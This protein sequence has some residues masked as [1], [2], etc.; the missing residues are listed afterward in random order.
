M[1]SLLS[2]LQTVKKMLFCTRMH[3]RV[4]SELHKYWIFGKSHTYRWNINQWQLTHEYFIHTASK[5]CCL[6]ATLDF[7]RNQKKNK[8]GCKLSIFFGYFFG[9]KPQ[10]RCIAFCKKPHIIITV[11]ITFTGN[12]SSFL[13]STLPL[14]F[15][16]FI[17][18]DN[19][20]RLR[21]KL[22]PFANKCYSGSSG[23]I[24]FD[25][26]SCQKIQNNFGRE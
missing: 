11:A 18:V 10:V 13:R 15:A 1:L 2:L 3:T 5:V 16:F 6:S 20:L 9:S 24:Y 17:Y 8:S 25:M 26:K 7:S 22:E 14:D 21:S 12:S 19:K 4:S 23:V